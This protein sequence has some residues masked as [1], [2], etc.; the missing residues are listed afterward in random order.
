[1]QRGHLFVLILV[2]LMAPVLGCGSGSAKQEQGK[3]PF[4]MRQEAQKEKAKEEYMKPHIPG[5]PKQ[6]K[7]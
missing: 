3:D 5:G 7:Q 2:I 1:M 6:P 4:K